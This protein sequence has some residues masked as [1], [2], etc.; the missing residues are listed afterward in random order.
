MKKKHLS[1]RQLDRIQQRQEQATGVSGVQREGLVL[2]NY[3][4]QADVEA[5]DGQDKGEVYRCFLR[6]NLDILVAGDRVIWEHAGDSAVVLAGLERRSLLQRPN[7][8]NELKPV[9]ANIDRLVIVVAPAPPPHYNLID[10]YIVAAEA[11]RIEPLVLLNKSDLLD[12][13]NRPELEAMLSLYANLGYPTAQVSSRTLAGL[14]TI[15]TILTGHTSIVVGQSG[16]GKSALVNALLPGVDT[17]EGSL[18][19]AGDKGRHTT[20]SAR[21]YHLP[22]G[23]DLIDSPGIREFGLW[24]MEPEELLRGFIEFRPFLGQCRFRDC[25]HDN[26][27]HCRVLQAVKEG[28]ID[29]RRLE[30]FQLIS[31]SMSEPH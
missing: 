4:R 28:R 7:K 11:S 5:L 20:T 8:Y 16:V 25:R 19:N 21:L 29:Q 12:E 23:G 17:T 30:S 1:K 26:P 31:N 3:G 22:Q 9:A 27:D 24:H 14:E 10:R 18:S 15:S 6:S 13:H 2:S